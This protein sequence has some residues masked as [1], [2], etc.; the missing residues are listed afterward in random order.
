MNMSSRIMNY[1]E[2]S[3]PLTA[4]EAFIQFIKAQ[5]DNVPE[6]EKNIRKK[7]IMD[8]ALAPLSNI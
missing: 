1:M 3:K 7:M 4:D 5:L 2:N 6:H 8:A